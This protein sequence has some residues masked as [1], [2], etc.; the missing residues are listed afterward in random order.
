[1]RPSSRAVHLAL[2]L[3]SRDWAGVLVVLPLATAGAW[4]V[5]LG[6]LPVVGAL[7]L[8]VAAALCAGSVHHL[9]DVGRVAR[10]YPPPG[11]MVDVGGHR[12]HV[13][14]EG[15]RAAGA[16]VV[17]MPG[18]H[19]GG[20]AMHHLHVLMKQE[21]RSVL[22]DRPGTGWSDP[23]PFPRTTATEAVELLTALERSGERPPF[24]LVGH[25]F[26]GLLVANAARRRPDL[27]AGLVLL[28][29]TPPDV[30]AFGPP[31]PALRRTASGQWWKA[32]RHLFGVHGKSQARATAP[33][34]GEGST[35]TDGAVGVLDAI[36]RRTR[37]AC[38]AASIFRELSPQGM[39]RV[40]WQTALHDGDLGT[41]PVVVVTPRDLT[42]AE[43]ALT[44]TGNPDESIR[45]RRFYTTVRGRYLTT[46]S[47]AWRVLTPEGTGHDFPD[48]VPEFVVDVV[49]SMADG[50]DAGPPSAR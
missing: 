39:A 47:R 11:R 3:L 38:A 12:M 50:Q 2:T 18:G 15:D 28:D 35:G 8:V 21:V 6:G 20:Y 25:S 17:W 7:L 27:V 9:V 19:V 46:S 41:L 10:R 42:T 43:E 24:V 45:L 49:R 29:P 37:A 22:V 36:E 16:T 5:A 23:G 33:L 26:G 34:Q 14:A 4:C 13:L 1:M 32:V 30:I 40:G 44:A 31:V 48:E